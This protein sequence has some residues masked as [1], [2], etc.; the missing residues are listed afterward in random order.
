M[1]STENAQGKRGLEVL[2]PVVSI[3]GEITFSKCNPSADP[4]IGETFNADGPVFN[5]ADILF[6]DN[7]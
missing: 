7:P 5:R 4:D 2:C 6:W 1:D 3:L